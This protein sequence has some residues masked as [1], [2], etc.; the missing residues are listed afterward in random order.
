MDPL[1]SPPPI[2]L[3]RC[4][5]MACLWPSPSLVKLKSVE[6]INSRARAVACGLLAVASLSDA[7]VCARCRSHRG[8]GSWLHLLGEIF[9][10]R[11]RAHFLL[12]IRHKPRPNRCSR[13]LSMSVLEPGR[14]RD[15]AARRRGNSCSVIVL[16]GKVLIR[17]QTEPSSLGSLTGGARQ[18]L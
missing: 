11:V 7:V 8:L 16:G 6:I 10:P 5:P 2:P 1:S 4:Q 17:G 12:P 15:L 18:G 3:D 14:G 13:V 9:A